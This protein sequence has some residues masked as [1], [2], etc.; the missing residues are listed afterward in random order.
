MTKNLF[1]KPATNKFPTKHVPK[2]VSKFLIDF[3][4]GKIKITPPIEV[5]EKFRGRLKYNS[6]KCIRCKQCIKVC[7]AEA[8]EFDDKQNI[9][10]HYV[11]RCTFCGQCVDICPAKCLE[12]TSDFL[13]STYDKNLGFIE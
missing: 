13:L 9:I 10:V 4:K 12:Q 5:P 6:D 11:A 2:N 7:P 3:S 1:S 8:L